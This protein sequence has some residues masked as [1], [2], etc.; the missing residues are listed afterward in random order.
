MFIVG[1]FSEKEFGDYDAMADRICEF[2]G[3]ETVYEY[4]AKGIRCHLSYGDI[5]SSEGRPK[6]PFVTTIPSIYES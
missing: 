3:Y 2:F 4:G 6:E 5:D 1:F